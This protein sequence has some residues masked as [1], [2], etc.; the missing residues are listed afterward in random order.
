MP[1]THQ[2]EV[3]EESRTAQQASL[4]IM[5][6]FFILQGA[7]PSHS[8]C[9]LYPVGRHCLLVSFVQVKPQH[10]C[11]KTKRNAPKT[12][13]VRL[14]GSMPITHHTHPA[15]HSAAVGRHRSASGNQR[16][17]DSTNRCCKVRHKNLKPLCAL[18]GPPRTWNDC[19][20]GSGSG[21]C[22]KHKKS[23]VSQPVASPKLSHMQLRRN[24]T[25]EHCPKVSRP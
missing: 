13:S 14:F 16:F 3:P 23:T 11:G 2:T 8:P 17:L 4:K 9:F 20:E 21:S 15:G 25:N 7:W 12:D 5:C 10:F 18:N 19:D 6:I 1:T 22:R 24:N